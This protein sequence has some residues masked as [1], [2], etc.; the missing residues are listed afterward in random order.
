ML[1]TTGTMR[2]ELRSIHSSQ[3]PQETPERALVPKPPPLGAHGEVQ[4]AGVPCGRSA[5][6]GGDVP[7]PTGWFAYE[8]SCFVDC[9]LTPG[10]HSERA[11]RTPG[12]QVGVLMVAQRGFT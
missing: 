5:V 11:E 7:L 6:F 4:C 10:D 12:T 9:F 1:A 2:V 8:P 3:S